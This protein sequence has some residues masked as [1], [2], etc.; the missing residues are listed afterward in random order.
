LLDASAV[1]CDPQTSGGLFVSVDPA[2]VDEIV[3]V[4]SQLGLGALHSIGVI[5][6]RAAQRNAVLIVSEQRNSCG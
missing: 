6:E 2:H 1:L 3:A 4:A 5:Q